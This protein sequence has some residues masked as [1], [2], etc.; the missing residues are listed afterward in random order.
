M[1]QAY[2]I[3][4]V[5]SSRL[6]TVDVNASMR[7]QFKQLVG[8]T[9]QRVIFKRTGSKLIAVVSDTVQ[10]FK[11]PNA[12]QYHYEYMTQNARSLWLSVPMEED[13]L[14][15]NMLEFVEFI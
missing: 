11:K 15:E 3:H 8:D 14:I 6:L 9:F 10:V 2:S 5:G 4:G 7:Y 13:K 12:I 1:S